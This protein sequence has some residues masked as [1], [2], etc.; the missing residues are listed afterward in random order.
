VIGLEE[1]S[2]FG[3][4]KIFRIAT[5][6]F[7]IL[8]NAAQGM[9]SIEESKTVALALITDQLDEWY[10]YFKSID[11]EFKHDFDPKSGSAH[12]GFVIYDPEGYLLEFE[13]FNNHPENSGLNPSLEKN[14]TI[15]SG[16]NFSYDLGIKATVT[17]LYYKDLPKVM[18]FYEDI[19]GLKLVA[20]QGWA[21]IYRLT[22]S[23]FIGLVD[24]KKGMH[25]YSEEKSLN[26][27]FII[28]D[29]DGW[30]SEV[31]ENKLFPIRSDQ[32]KT[33]SEKRYREFVG[34]DPEGYFLEFDKFYPHPE[35]VKL[36]EYLSEL[37]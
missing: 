8:V 9:H 4:A 32:M 20:D 25:K 16:I 23:S 2:D 10:S 34:Y 37:K 6:S 1:I 35:N 7:L 14:E 17:W 19:I 3:M 26:V 29:L 27:S 36:M 28:D 31:R 15:Y 12:D 11:T 22:N 13:R 21:K 24:E 30:F 33:G 5:G 18:D